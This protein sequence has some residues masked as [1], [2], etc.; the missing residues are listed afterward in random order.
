MTQY[1]CSATFLF[2]PALPF[3]SCPDSATGGVVISIMGT[4]GF[5]WDLNSNTNNNPF[6][7]APIGVEVGDVIC[8]DADGN[9]ENFFSC[10]I[11]SQFF[12]DGVPIT[13]QF[14]VCPAGGLTAEL[15]Q[16]LVNTH[17]T[18]PNVTINVTNIGTNIQVVITI[19]DNVIHTVAALQV[20]VDDVPFILV[21]APFVCNVI[22]KRKRKGGT[23]ISNTFCINKFDIYGKQIQPK[24]ILN[25]NGALYYHPID[26]GN[27][28]CYILYRNTD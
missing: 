25:I 4:S 10:N 9:I 6:F 15:N 19:T 1:S 24:P 17:L 12:I 16:F 11:E 26:Y 18:N 23:G 14:P 28:Y 22:R 5:F 2:P 20:F 8:V 3:T 21:E 27:K 7:N 13:S